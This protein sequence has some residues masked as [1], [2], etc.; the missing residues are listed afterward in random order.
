M[1]IASYHEK[2]FE[3]KRVEMDQQT[4][5][6]C[7]WPGALPIAACLPSMHGRFDFSPNILHSR[8]MT[9]GYL[10]IYGTMQNKCSSTAVWP[11]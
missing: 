5:S 2:E 9:H 8:Q 6:D 11:R 7:N 3:G 4:R 1:R 10:R